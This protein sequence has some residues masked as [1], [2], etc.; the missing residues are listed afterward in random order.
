M[1]IEQLG[2][3]YDLSQN[4]NTSLIVFLPS[5]RSKKIYPYYPRISWKSSLPG[6]DTLYLA[7]PFQE[8]DGYQEAGGSWF[9]RP[10]G[11]SDLPRIASILDAWI[12]KSC[13]SKVIFYGSSMGGYAA[14]VLASLIE[15]QRQLQ[16]A[17]RFTWNVI[18]VV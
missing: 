5:V 10:D 2:F 9:I 18:Q 3:G 15:K 13:Y 12:T 7:D 11:N 16:N 6:Y 8:F 1:S 14:L 4:G 17:H